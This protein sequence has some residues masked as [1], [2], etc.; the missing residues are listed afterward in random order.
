MSEIPPESSPEPQIRESG[1]IARAVGI[2]SSA[3]ALS[4]ILGLVRD[5]VTAAYF[6]AGGAMDAF[7]VAFRL[8]NTLRRLFAE[9]SLTVAFVPVFVDALE[10]EGAE[11]AHTLGR[12]G[13]TLLGV[14]LALVSVMGVLGA[15]WL[16]RATAWGFTQDPEK[17]DLTVRLTRLVFPSSPWWVSQPSPAGCSTL[18]ACSRTRPWP[19]WSSTR[20]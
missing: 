2:L 11:R 17:F 6:G 10:T 7:F 15:P 5:V 12:R 20:A 14:V 16:V 1:R 13:L 4:R 19:R 3:T 8:P 18:G 9:G